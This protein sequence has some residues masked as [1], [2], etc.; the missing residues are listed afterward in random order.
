MKKSYF[1]FLMSG[2]FLLLCLASPLAAQDQATSRSVE[3]QEQAVDAQVVINQ[4][5]TSAF[6][7][8]T[9]FASVIKNGVPLKGLGAGDFRVR[10]DEID[11]EPIT[12]VPKLTPLNA[13][14]A[15][16][17]S[18]SMKQRMTD[19]Q[20]AAKSFINLLRKLTKNNLPFMPCGI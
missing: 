14:V 3:G 5:D 7:K 1:L 12:V 6:P 8:V 9:L 20:S 4:I 2:I 13:V 17:T 10:E 18:G 15:L 19:A 16:D 11:Q